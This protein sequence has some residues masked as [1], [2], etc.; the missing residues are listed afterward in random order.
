MPLMAATGATAADTGTWDKVAQCESG[1]MWSANTGNGF[2]GGLQ[3]TQEMWEQGG[4]ISYAPRADLASRSQQIAVAERILAAQGPDAWRSCAVSSGL[5]KGSPAP[6]VN[7]GRVQTPEP[8]TTHKPAPERTTPA[9]PEHETPKPSAPAPGS[10]PAPEKSQTPGTPSPTTDPSAPATGTPGEADG[11]HRKDP[12]AEP[13]NGP[14][15]PAG[16]PTGTP[17]AT[18]S[19]TPS[20]TPA[21]PAPGNAQTPGDTSGEPG[22]GKHRAEPARPDATDRPSRDGGAG[23]TDLPAAD[24]YTVRPGDNL[25]AIAQEHAV[26]GGWQTLYQKNEKTVGSDPDLIQP[27]QR[28]DIRK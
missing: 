6:D 14:T 3:L 4:G 20:G 21:E 28:L 2:F 11:K 24:D 1:R 27:G 25:S 17:S 18:P 9:T 19:G 10:T 13:S 23:R 8:E 16:T 12:S 15:T 26:A 22:T 5:S 7:P